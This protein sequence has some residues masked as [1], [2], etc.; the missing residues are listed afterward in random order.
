MKQLARIS[1]PWIAAALSLSACGG[2]TDPAPPNQP[3]TAIAGPAQTVLAGDTVTLAGSGTDPE[4]DVLTYAWSFTKPASSV[5][6]LQN[7]HVATPTFVADL[8]GTYTATLVVNDKL[9]D[10]A[11]STVIVTAQVPT[12]AFINL[13]SGH[14]CTSQRRVVVIDKHLVYTESND[15]QCADQNIYRLYES[16]PDHPLCTAGGLVVVTNIC[17]NGDINDTAM[18][19]TIIANLRKPDLGL[20]SAH[21]VEQVYSQGL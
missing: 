14:D 15:L 16:T 9:H 17:P 19:E 7:A 4:A 20:G 5:A 11:P 1:A 10:S 8:V 18:M 21:T 6:T 12:Q 2:G 13:W 3:P